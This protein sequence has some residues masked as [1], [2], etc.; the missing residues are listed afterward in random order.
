MK[1]STILTSVNS[2]SNIT[3]PTVMGEA[4]ELSSKHAPFHRFTALA[5]SNFHLH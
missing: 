1:Y 4:E 5:I 2:Q 3:T